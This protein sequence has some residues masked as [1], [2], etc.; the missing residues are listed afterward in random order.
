M[1]EGALP[2]C[3]IIEDVVGFQP[4]GQVLTA[5]AVTA[6]FPCQVRVLIPIFWNLGSVKE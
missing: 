4:E 6:G 3:P 5:K 1:A 2:A